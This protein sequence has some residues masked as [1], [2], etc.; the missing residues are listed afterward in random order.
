MVRID[1]TLF[2]ELYQKHSFVFLWF[3]D[4]RW[5]VR[6]LWWLEVWPPPIANGVLNDPILFD[7]ILS[8]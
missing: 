6:I 1:H 7:A 4:V 8:A 5:Y 3:G 2:V